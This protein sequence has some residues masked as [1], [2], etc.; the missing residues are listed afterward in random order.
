MRQAVHILGVVVAAFG[1][2]FLLQGLDIVHWPASSFMLGGQAWVG[3]G[4]AIAV[5]GLLIS[6]PGDGYPARGSV[7]VKRAPCPG[8][9]ST[10]RSPPMA[11][12]SRRAM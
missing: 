9:L 10:V 11:R 1:V 7:K 4:A 8:V 2:L 3:R 6:S 12:A 5:T